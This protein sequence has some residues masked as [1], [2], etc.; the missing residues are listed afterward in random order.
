M[1]IVCTPFSRFSFLGSLFLML[2]ASTTRADIVELNPKDTPEEKINL[3]PLD[4]GER[5]LP[6]V[7]IVRW[8]V[9]YTDE[10]RALMVE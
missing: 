7:E 4:L 6:E 1:G 9:P 2:T 10:R 3:E 5:P 8:L